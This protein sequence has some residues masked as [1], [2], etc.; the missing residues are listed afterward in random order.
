MF[1]DPSWLQKKKKKKTTDHA[2]RR[3]SK[4]N[5]R[6]YKNPELNIFISELT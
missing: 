1:A 5:K 3:G 4:T 2:T 6:T